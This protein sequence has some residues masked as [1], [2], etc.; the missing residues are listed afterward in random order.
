[1]TIIDYKL[2]NL[3]IYAIVSNMIILHLTDS[4]LL[5]VKTLIMRS[6][7]IMLDYVSWKSSAPR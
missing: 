7:G 6:D 3:Q 1:M 2:N 5:S 4:T